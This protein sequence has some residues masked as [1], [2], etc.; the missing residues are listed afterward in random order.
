MRSFWIRIFVTFWIIEI[1][2][3]AAL[4]SLRGSLEDF[5]LYPVS[6]KALT[7]MAFS[8]EEAYQ[9]AQCD[10]LK[11]LLSR[12]E[13]V[14]KVTPHLFDAT[15]RAVCSEAVSPAVQRA[16]DKSQPFGLK[17]VVEIMRGV[18]PG[19]NGQIIASVRINPDQNSP[20]IF[21]IET[22]QIPP[23]TFR[24]KGE[25]TFFA[26]V[27]F[28]G[29]LSA[30]LAKILV[31]PIGQLRR[32]A[33]E[34]ASG[35]L[36]ARANNCWRLPSKGNEV[37]AL[38]H[39]FNRMADQIESLI[40]MQ[41]QLIRDVSHELRSPLS[42]LSVALEL[43]REDTNEQSMVHVERIER[44]TERLNR[45]IGQLL[46]LS[47]M[48]ALEGTG[49]RTEIVQLEDIVRE[50]VSNAAYEAGSRGCNVRAAIRDRVTVHANSELLSSAIENVVRNGIRYT[51]AG[52]DV[53]VTLDCQRQGSAPAAKLTVR[54]FGPGVPEDKI[55][56]L[57]M[58]FYRVDPARSNETGGTGVGLAIADRA[59]R[60][61]GGSLSLRNHPEGGLEVTL[62]L[63]IVKPVLDR[64]VQ[65]AAA[66]MA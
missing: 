18:S 10:E 51:H 40:G 44:E 2:T 15:G 56:S 60:L 16:A 42:R 54:D 13:R 9:A 63:P 20:F 32:T 38:F 11:P 25:L 41:K 22:T 27:L 61:H 6:E 34:L 59:V 52:T 50:V 33:Q 66:T 5:T 65:T 58:P 30:L 29:I 23:W 48:E 62:L 17:R 31:L 28:S 49:I 45:L 24:F 3:I 35:N 37:L 4:I 8:A 7:S 12:F 46:E 19:R 55:P 26:G 64:E 39:D 47:R 36:K 43:L 1:L 57:R 53:L 21:V 14:Y